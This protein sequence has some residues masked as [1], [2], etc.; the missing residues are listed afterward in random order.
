[1]Q[2]LPEAPQFQ[3]APTWLGLF[4]M[5]GIGL[6]FVAFVVVVSVLLAAGV[7][8]ISS[9][10]IKAIGALMLFII[11]A[12]A[13]VGMIGMKWGAARTHTY[14]YYPSAVQT[15]LETNDPKHDSVPVARVET[16]KMV[17]P[18]SKVD[19]ATT[20]AAVIVEAED[21][22]DEPGRRTDRARS[23]LASVRAVDGADH[24]DGFSAASAAQT[25]I[26]TSPLTGVLR[27][28]GTASAPPDWA[29]KEP[30]LG[31]D[32]VLVAL[33]SQRFA[34][35]G[36]AEE[37]VTG[38]AVECVKKFYRDEYPLPGQ[39]TVPVSV[40]E[41]NALNTMVGEMYD[42]DFGNG[43]TGKMY[44]AHLRLSLS[45]TLRDA[46]HASW[47]DQVVAHR[48]LELGSLL[49]LATLALAT[50]AGY[51]RLDDLTGG[52]YRRRLKLAAASLI[53][54][55]SLVAWQVLV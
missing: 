1:M 9:R 45:P 15:A 54:A 36:E 55:G 2:S 42:Q 6:A 7:H 18:I 53:A 41:Q 38:Q 29:G 13:V 27:V 33:S 31:K 20:K 14:H 21:T 17:K 51:F 34:T 30:V 37:Q 44:R 11:P 12:I 48:L 10:R 16:G 8:V 35:I 47:H 25:L 50:C 49:G 28:R 22:A 46:L 32:G 40:I 52:Q 19:E 3:I 24:K 43:V 4:A 23:Q 26:S 5:L 39:W